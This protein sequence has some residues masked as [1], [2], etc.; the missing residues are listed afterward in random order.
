MDRVSPVV[1]RSWR[2]VEP[3]LRVD[4]IAEQRGLRFRAGGCGRADVWVYL[5]V[6][7]MVH[8]TARETRVSSAQFVAFTMCFSSH[9]FVASPAHRGV[10]K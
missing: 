8:R 4:E 3:G 6:K 10:L 2:R 9:F 5:S 1:M 7:G